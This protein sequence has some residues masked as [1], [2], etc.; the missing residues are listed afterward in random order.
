LTVFRSSLRF[1]LFLF[2][3]ETLVALLFAHSRIFS[4]IFASV[5]FFLFHGIL[6]SVLVLFLLFASFRFFFFLQIWFQVFALVYKGSNQIDRFSF[7]I[8]FLFLLVS[9]L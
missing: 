6:F 5:F 9:D 8:C 1:F 7:L 2:L 4:Y 3:H